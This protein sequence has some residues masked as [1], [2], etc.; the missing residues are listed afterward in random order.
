M[1][2][3]FG[4]LLLYLFLRRFS[5]PEMKRLVVV[6]AAIF[7]LW[8]YY[9][10]GR[11]TAICLREARVNSEDRMAIESKLATA[12][13]KLP[14][15]S[16]VMMHLGEHGGA[17]Q[18]IGF[19]LKRTINECHKRY[20]HSALM[21]PALMADFI[22]AAD[23]DPIALAVK[24]HPEGLVRVAEITWPRQSSI[25]IYRSTAWQ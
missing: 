15:D 18:Q 5:W 1:F 23:G 6:G 22:V 24:E 20:W 21:D 11:D 10:V 3:V 16:T 8:S 14:P 12:L 17:L 4:A 13:E 9:T 7:V 19:P 25:A 2:A